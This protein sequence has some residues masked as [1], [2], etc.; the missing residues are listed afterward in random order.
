MSL[1]NRFCLAIQPQPRDNSLVILG[2]LGRRF[3]FC[4]SSSSIQQFDP[5][6]LFSS[7]FCRSASS[8]EVRFGRDKPSRTMAK[9]IG[10]A[11][12]VAGLVG[13]AGQLLNGCI[14]VKGFLGDAKDTP[15]DI[16]DLHTEM[17]ILAAE[18]GKLSTLSEN[19]NQPS[20]VMN[21]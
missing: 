20:R 3:R 19:S 1:S 8:D 9:A 18:A 4:I 11:P 21:G 14:F 16:R 2:F 6:L 5:V 12:S 13:L 17:D 10:L 7:V 15:T